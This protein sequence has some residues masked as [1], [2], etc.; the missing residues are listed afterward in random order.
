MCPHEEMDVKTT[1]YTG[2]YFIHPEVPRVVGGPREELAHGRKRSG[3][4]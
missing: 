1:Y 3:E 4:Q 2:K